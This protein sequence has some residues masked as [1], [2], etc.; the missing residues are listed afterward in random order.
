MLLV[1]AL[2]FVVGDDLKVG[3]RV[4]AL[5]V[6]IGVCLGFISGFVENPPEA[7]VIGHRYFGWPFVWR[8]TKTLLP[9]EYRYSELFVDLM[10][11]IVV[12]LAVVLLAKMLMKS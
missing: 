12:V 8:I 10:F 2:G 7:S 4:P 5:A 11:W 6:V 9:E 3:W 1:V